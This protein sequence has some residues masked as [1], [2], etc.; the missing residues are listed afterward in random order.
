[1]R[2]PP[3]QRPKAKDTLSVSFWRSFAVQALNELGYRW[4]CSETHEADDLI[5]TCVSEPKKVMRHHAELAFERSRTEASAARGQICKDRVQR[6]GLAAVGEQEGAHLLQIF[7][8]RVRSFSFTL[9]NAL[10]SR[11]EMDEPNSLSSLAS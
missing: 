2:K 3:K 4:M 10:S 6:Q 8:V 11:L 7:D 1:M 9:G 5:A